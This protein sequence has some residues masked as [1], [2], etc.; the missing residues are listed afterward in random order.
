MHVQPETH[1]GLPNTTQ[2]AVLPGVTSFRDLMTRVNQALATGALTQA[3]LAEACKA[4]NVGSIVELAAQP[5]LV[6]A[7]ADYLRRWIVI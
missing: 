2:Q 1:A 4:K 6:P 3:Q 7:I 5:L